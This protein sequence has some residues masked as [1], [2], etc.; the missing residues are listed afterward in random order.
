MIATKTISA[1]VYVFDYSKHPSKPASGARV[2][3]IYAGK[4]G[5]EVAGRGDFRGR[6]LGGTAR[7]GRQ[8]Q[9]VR[10]APPNAHCHTVLP[11]HSILAPVPQTASASL[12][13]G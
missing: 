2:R 4:R 10:G 6:R 12:T 3:L 5:S 9:R 8:S 7:G 13:F 11:N 1:E